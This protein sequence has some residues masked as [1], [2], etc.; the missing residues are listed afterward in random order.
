ML[1]LLSWSWGRVDGLELVDGDDDL[2][3]DVPVDVVDGVG[4]RGVTL[5]G[6]VHSLCRRTL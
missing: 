6:Q 3:V 2:D 1:L 4:D 5:P